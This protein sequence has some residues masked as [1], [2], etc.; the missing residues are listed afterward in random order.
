[1]MPLATEGGKSLCASEV[2]GDCRAVKSTGGITSLSL[3]ERC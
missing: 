2:N 3:G 1:M